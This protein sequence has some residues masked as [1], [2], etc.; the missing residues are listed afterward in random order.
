MESL[1]PERALLCAIILRALF[2]AQNGDGDAGHWLETEGYP[3]ADQLLD[4]RPRYPVKDVSKLHRARGPLPKTADQIEARK[5]YMREYN[6]TRRP[7][8]RKAKA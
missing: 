7:K 6:R 3:M 8:R 2:D 1:R 4:L 5:A